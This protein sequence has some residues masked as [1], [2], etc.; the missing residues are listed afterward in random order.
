MKKEAPATPAYRIHPGI[1]I[2][3]LGDSPD[4][5]CISP[6]TPASLPIDC[7]AD[8]NPR[9]SPDG[10]S[11][12][13]VTQFKDAA[14][15]IKRQAARF[16]LYVY[17]EKSPE[18]RPLRIGDPI[19]GGGNHGV[20]VDIQWRVYLA[21]KKAVWYTFNSLT[22][23][24]GYAADHPLRNADIVDPNVRQQ[25]IIDPGP[26]IV[27]TK[28]ERRGSFSRNRDDQYA[29][30]FPP[31]LTPRSIDTLG[32]IL[33]DDTGRLLVL[34]GHGHSGS[35]KT[36]FGQPRIDT[37]ANTD[38]WF[39]D[40]SD[41]PVMA[42][43]VMYSEQVGATRYI[44]VESPAW[45]IVGYPRY[46][47]QILDMVTLDDVV[48][49]LSIRQFA[50]RTD[51]YGAAGTFNNPQIIDP[52]NEAALQHWLAGR[53]TWNAEYKPWFYRDVWPILFRA[54]EFTYL[55][56][57]LEQSNF[58]HNQTKRGNFDPEKLSRPPRVR[59]RAVARE[60]AAAVAQCE[61]GELVAAALAAAVALLDVPDGIDWE[62]VW[63]V[64]TTENPQLITDV[65][66]AAAA[67]ADVLCPPPAIAPAAYLERWRTSYAELQNTGAA[68]PKRQVYEV[69]RQVLD[70][71][72][73]TLADA[74]RA[75]VYPPTVLMFVAPAE[76][77]GPKAPDDSLDEAF[78]RVLNEFRTGAQLASRLAAIVAANPRD[79]D[80]QYRAFLYDLLRQP[81]EENVFRRG[82]KPNNR[83][84]NLPLMPL[85]NGDNP[86][87]NTLP[88]KFLKL[89]DYQ[90]YV[91]R[92]WA[93]GK[94][95]NEVQEGWVPKSEVNVYQPY[96][97]WQNK[98]AA[99]LDQGVL[100][101]L[102]GGAFC[103]GGEVGWIIRNPS[104]YQV[105]YRIK[106]DP[107]FSSFQQTAA[108]ANA[109]NY[110]PRD[111][112]AA[113][114]GDLSQQSD[115]ATGLQ[116]GDITKYSALPW[117]ADFNECTTQTVNIT[118]ELWNAID[119]TSENDTRMALQQQV[120]ETLW[121]PAHRPLQTFEITGLQ[122]GQP[123]GYRFRDWARGI[124]QTLAGDLKMVT[125][126]SRLGFV[127]AN[128]YLTPQQLDAPSPDQKYISVERN[129]KE[130]Q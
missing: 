67:Y 29:P 51:L 127:V 54:D 62:A 108:E 98:T 52:S 21:N 22:G 69:A 57:V 129:D 111:F 43:L 104:I 122:N 14:G 97:H 63:D 3:R 2:A 74:L 73:G 89:T 107:A 20:L 94:F 8:G 80:R 49:D 82:G 113:N 72:A 86:I 45:V 6:E 48:A 41:G 99:D 26:Q 128:P 23:E 32:D 118:Y 93:D 68:D 115:F 110:P 46:A 100:M 101:N 17:D 31:P 38:G 7:D 33:T 125:E 30:V 85:L 34:G 76:G 12:L 64:V 87:T 61:S 70:L 121:W 24:H 84:T 9:L 95:Y 18:G 42:R 77:F 130:P 117:Q 53:L 90:L 88:S 65:S 116:P 124:P 56:N 105:P 25:L 66:D 79:R 15:R 16:Q 112:L 81:G 92:Q 109:Q 123:T 37:Y 59:H 71:A 103:P 5:F 120:W 10:E 91:L 35:F 75:A 27:N 119:P 55:T 106:A 58:P 39:D 13:T 78:E 96:Q 60:Q 11:E 126:W 50:A 40:T 47:P 19:E 114:I 1:G 28:T 4:E 44:D 83:T 102:L 36:G